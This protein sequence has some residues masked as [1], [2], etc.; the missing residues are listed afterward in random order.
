MSEVSAETGRYDAGSIQVLEGLEAVR[1]RPSMY[2][3]STS[4][5]GLHHLVWEVVDNSVDEAQAGYCTRIDVRLHDFD[6]VS[7]VDNG[8]G[9]PIDIHE[10]TNTP[11][12]EVVMTT[13]HAGGKFDNDAYRVS[14]GLHGVGV[15]VVNALSEWLE[16]EV[17]KDGAKYM[18]RY[19]RGVP[20]APLA[21]IGEAD[22]NGT[23]VTFRPDTEI[24]ETTEFS[25]DTLS[26]RLRELAFLNSGLLISLS[27]DRSEATG[28]HF[29]FRY[30]GG[31]VTFVRFL[32]QNRHTLHPEPIFI[33]RETAL[34]DGGFLLVESA[35]QYNNGYQEEVFSFAN[36]INTVDGG[37]HLTGFRAAI[38][39][40]LNDY[41]TAS[42]VFKKTD[43][44]FSGNDV[45]EG[46]TAVVSIK[47]SN[48]Q[49]EG[50]T[51]ARLGNRDVKGSVESIVYAGISQ[52]LEENPAVARRIVQK[53]QETSAARQAA[54]KARELTRRKS[55][56]ETAALPGKLADCVVTDPTDA[57]LFLVEGDSAGGS[58]KQGRNRQNQA[59]LPL[60]G[61]ILNV[62][63][64]PLHKILNNNEIKTIVTAVGTGIGD[65]DFDL[66]RLRYGRIIIMT[67]A[68]VDGA[69]IR[70][71]LLTFFYRYM[72][73][74]ISMGHIFI[75][76]PPLFGVRH[77]KTHRYAYSEKEL[78]AVLKAMGEEKP[79]I[80]RYKGLG[81]MN[82][83]QLWATTMNP[84]SR[85][86]LKVRMEDAVEASRTFSI[87]MG[88]EVEPRRD[89][90]QR[91]A[92]EVRNLDV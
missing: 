36:N 85:T 90:I 64:A 54:R 61:K 77:G 31:I 58:A 19:E 7:V 2:I 4:E 46:L 71:L 16:V 29:D 80:Q 25:F 69:H 22:E 81:E 44:A 41:A 9:I 91:H 68:D 8:R 60:R 35:F 13:L 59:V 65:D 32:N 24:F 73:S 43:E 53:C 10:K 14:G 75:A 21:R 83:E 87:L 30:E 72:P 67:D 76:Q 84:E 49:F 57:E 38:T 39:R 6:V 26:R 66:A 11:A 51:K 5:V 88:D 89:F 20:V 33:R 37:T 40:V 56:L 47:L 34:E 86:L 92:A 12:L 74:L 50:Q 42:G 52:Y 62:E 15:S 48:P 28:K 78:D 63:K 82:P 70:T 17:C 79:V 27:D 45:R 55:A 1:K 3:G 18:Q 23:R